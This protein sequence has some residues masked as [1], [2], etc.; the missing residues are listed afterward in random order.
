MRFL[1]CLSVVFAAPLIAQQS[2]PTISVTGA[3]ALYKSTRPLAT[4]AEVRESLR[5]LGNPGWY[6]STDPDVF[7][8]PLLGVARIGTLGPFSLSAP[9]AA[10]L[11]RTGRRKPAI[12]RVR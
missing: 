11:T 7:H 1:F 3:V 8:E 10:S 2:T 6:T 4:P 9:T 5:Y 12:A